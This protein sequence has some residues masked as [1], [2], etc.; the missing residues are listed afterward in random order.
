MLVNHQWRMKGKVRNYLNLHKQCWGLVKA[1]EIQLQC[2]T[3]L[4]LFCPMD[5]RV[6]KLHDEHFEYWVNE[7]DRTSN[8]SLFACGVLPWGRLW[9]RPLVM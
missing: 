7:V 3:G 4:R 8:A 1:E 6:I 5:I 9:P 2:T